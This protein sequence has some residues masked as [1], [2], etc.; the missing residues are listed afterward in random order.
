MSTWSEYIWGAL[1]TTITTT[2]DHNA[3]PP[4]VEIDTLPEYDTKN[5]LAPHFQWTDGL[6]PDF[7]FPEEYELIEKV[8]SEVPAAIDYP[9]RFILIFLFARRH[10]VPHCV[11]LLTKHLTWLQTMGFAPV[12][13]TN[14][15]PFSPELLTDSEKQYALKEGPLLYKHM[16]VDKQGRLLQYVRPRCWIHGR[17]NMKKLIGVVIW[18]YYYAFQHV[19]LSIHR[20]GMAVVI[21]MKDMGWANLDF[22]TDAQ[23]FISQAL[24]CFP[25][26]M[27]H[28]WIVNSNW[29]FSTAWSLIKLVLSAKV[30]ARMQPLAL[31]KLVEE[32]DRE[33]IPKELGGDWEPDVQR[34]WYEKV[35]ELDRIAKEEKDK[36]NQENK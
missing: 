3:P 20:N 28:A 27:R 21:D 10:S 23:Q 13:R 29:I 24:T 17:I 16:L 30:L 4:P 19:P 34:E 7:I 8:R 32:I 25:G 15:Y 1:P 5:G 11:K 33:Y 14:S 26:R 6:D 9:P 31:D 12:T 22:S 35:F 36:R 18:W 2:P